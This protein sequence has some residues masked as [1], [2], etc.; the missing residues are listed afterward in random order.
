MAWIDGNDFFDQAP[1]GFVICQPRGGIESRV[2]KEQPGRARDDKT[3]MRIVRLG[4]SRVMGRPAVGSAEII[5]PNQLI[6]IGEGILVEL[7]MAR[8]R[9]SDRRGT[10]GH[11]NGQRKPEQSGP[12]KAGFKSAGRESRRCGRWR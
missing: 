3:M 11:A 9:L 6:G 8:L 10:S 7:E 5:L 1:I 4:E 2:F 12:R